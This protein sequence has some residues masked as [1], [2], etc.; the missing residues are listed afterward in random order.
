LKL[1]QHRELGLKSPLNIFQVAELLDNIR[2]SEEKLSDEP[3]GFA[4]ILN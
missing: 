4:L 3:Q 2:Y 1:D